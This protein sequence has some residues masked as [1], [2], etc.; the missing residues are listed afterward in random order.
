MNALS[1]PVKVYGLPDIRFLPLDEWDER[2]PVALVTSGPAWAAVREDL[3]LQMAW[4]GSPRQATLSHWQEMLAG[5][6]GEV[7]Y[8]V[9]GGLAADAAKFLAAQRNLPLVCIPTALSVDAFFTWASGVREGGCVRYIETRPPDLLLVDLDVI[10]TAPPSLRAA[11]IC[12]VLS[13]ATALW[14]WRFAEERGQNPPGMAY[15]EWVAAVARGILQGALDCAEAAGAGDPDGLLSLVQ[16]LALEVLLC[17]L[18]GHSRPEEGSEHYFAYAVEEEV[19]P[20]RSHAE[21]VGPGILLMAR[22]Q[23]QE[24]APLE[25]ALRACHV[26]LD[27][28]PQEVVERTLRRLPDYAARHRLPFGIAHVLGAEQ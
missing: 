28:I 14:D 3:R 13:I 22:A 21:L 25:R 27:A 7:V 19:G 11:G 5:L 9:G 10:A 2:R 12:D 6:Q 26:P 18:V 8:A 20:G 15:A 4:R 1:L 17:N 16:C 24:T 23:G